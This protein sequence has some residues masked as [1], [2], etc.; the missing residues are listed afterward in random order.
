MSYIYVKWQISSVL[1]IHHGLVMYYNHDYKDR[2]NFKNYHHHRNHEVHL[3][4][5]RQSEVVK[6]LP[7]SSSKVVI[8]LAETE[9]QLKI[10][11][12]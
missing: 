10:L 12:I 3:F 7:S 2:K 6:L 5:K 8:T 11:I 4:A 1:K 9:S